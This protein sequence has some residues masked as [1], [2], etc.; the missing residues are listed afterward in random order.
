MYVYIFRHTVVKN[1]YN[2]R[3]IIYKNIYVDYNLR[4]VIYKNKYTTVRLCKTLNNQL[5]SEQCV[6][7]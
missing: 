5:T 2:V 6:V 3:K 4:T 7:R 1:V